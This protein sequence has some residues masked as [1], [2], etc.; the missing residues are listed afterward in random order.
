M[1]VITTVYALY[2]DLHIDWGLFHRMSNANHRR[3]PQWVYV[4]A[5]ATNSIFRAA[6]AVIFFP[7]AFGIDKELLHYV[8]LILAMVEV[9]RRALWNVLRIENEALN[10]SGGFRLVKDLPDSALF[11]PDSV[12]RAVTHQP[13]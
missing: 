5:I 6:W 8:S 3:F 11:H 2:W 7:R 12:L 1:A 10:N 4:S 13:S 9:L